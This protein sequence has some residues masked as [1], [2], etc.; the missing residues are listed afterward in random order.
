MLNWF[1]KQYCLKKNKRIMFIFPV[2]SFA[3]QNL[4]IQATTLRMLVFSYNSNKKLCAI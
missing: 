1:N 4:L 2:K 3:Y